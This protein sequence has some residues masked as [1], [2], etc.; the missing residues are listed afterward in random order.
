MNLDAS[1]IRELM[2]YVEYGSEDYCVL[3]LALR[4]VL[5]S[6]PVPD[7]E[8]QVFDLGLNATS[9]RGEHLP[10]DVVNADLARDLRRRLV[11]AEKRAH[12]EATWHNTLAPKLEAAERQF[13]DHTVAVGLFLNELYV[14]M[15]DPCAEG[16]VPVDEC[17]N[18]LIKA[19]LRDRENASQLAEAVAK[20]RADELEDVASFLHCSE[21][22]R[23]KLRNRAAAIRQGSEAYVPVTFTVMELETIHVRDLDGTGSLHVCAAGDPGAQRYVSGVEYDRMC[24]RRDAAS[25]VSLTHMRAREAAVEEGLLVI[26]ASQYWLDEAHRLKRALEEAQEHIGIAFH[27]EL[28]WALDPTLYSEQAIKDRFEQWFKREWPLRQDPL[29]DTS[30]KHQLWAVVRGMQ[31]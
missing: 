16:V 28:G 27:P 12:Y 17:K 4:Q 31:P 9:F 25:L 21:E 26:E 29:R 24:V 22:E 13:K 18:A 10:K 2:S 5:S 14:T 1:R 8:M 6:A 11:E 20:A 3:D 30:F 7:V 23:A 19:A 15:V